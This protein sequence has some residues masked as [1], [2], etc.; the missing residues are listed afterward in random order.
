MNSGDLNFIP[1]SYHYQKIVDKPHNAQ[2]L[3]AWRA[4]NP[5]RNI[6][7]PAG[8]STEFSGPKGRAVVTISSC[9]L[10]LR[11]TSVTFL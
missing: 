7:L 1:G 11:T 3:D 10:K 6:G 5:G 2:L 8:Y 9:P 4:L